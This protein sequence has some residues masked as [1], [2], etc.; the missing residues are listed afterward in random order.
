VSCVG[1]EE[2]GVRERDGDDVDKGHMCDVRGTAEEGDE[3]A[4]NVGEVG[5]GV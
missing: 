4:G 5:G 2:G 1:G 3:G